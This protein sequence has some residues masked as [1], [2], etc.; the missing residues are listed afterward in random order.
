MYSLL[1]QCFV[2]AGVT[3]NTTPMFSVKGISVGIHVR[4]IISPRK[5]SVT[6]VGY[7]LLL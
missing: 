7:T 4:Y 2:M 5:P 6:L 1:A 3:S